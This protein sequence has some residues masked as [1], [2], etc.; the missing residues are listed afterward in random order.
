MAKDLRAQPLDM[1]APCP[2]SSRPRTTVAQ[3]CVDRPSEAGNPLAARSLASGTASSDRAGEDY[4][5]TMGS[6]GDGRSFGAFV[7]RLTLLLASSVEAWNRCM[8]GPRAAPPP[9]LGGRVRNGTSVSGQRSAVSGQRSAVSGQRS[10]VSGQRSAVSGQRSAVSGQRSAV[11]GQRSAVSGQ[12]SA[13]SGQRSAVSGQRSAVSGQRSAVSGQR[14]AV[15]G[16]LPRGGRSCQGIRPRPPRPGRP[17]PP[18]AAR[19]RPLPP[20]RRRARRGGAA[21]ALDAVGAVSGH[22]GWTSESFPSLSILPSGT[23]CLKG[24]TPDGDRLRLS[25]NGRHL[26]GTRSSQP[27]SAKKRT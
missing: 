11:S 21:R 5:Y 23:V 16:I 14:S 25:A 22:E 18:H 13:V 4:N 19:S 20:A 27:R 6:T 15:S 24:R 3:P 12:R 7:G 1:T 26:L 8:S 17:D 9:E 10:A 2:V